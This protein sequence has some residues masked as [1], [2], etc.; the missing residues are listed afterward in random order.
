MSNFQKTLDDIFSVPKIFM[1]MIIFESNFSFLPKF[2]IIRVEIFEKLHFWA[3]IS[4]Y[5]N[6]L[7]FYFD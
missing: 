6:F 3:R 4:V 1:I 7:Q 5:H 2:L